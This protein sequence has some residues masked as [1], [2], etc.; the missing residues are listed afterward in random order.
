MPDLYRIATVFG[1]TGFIGR[2]IVRALAQRGIMVRVATR[3][4]ERAFFLKPC[5]TPGQIVPVACRYTDPASLSAAVRGS[6]YVVNCIGLL[7]ETRRL[8]FNQAHIEIPAAI[9]RA[10]RDHKVERFVHLSALGIDQSQSRYACTKREGEAAVREAFPAATILRPSVVFGPEDNFF[11]KFASLSRV[12][13]F[14]PL[15]GGGRTR[16]QPVFVDDV[17]EAAVCA[18]TRSALRAPDP[19]GQVFELGGPE[20]VDFPDI[21]RKLFRFTGRSRPLV[22]LPWSIARIQA[23]FLGLMPSPLLTND[24][25]ELLRSDAIVAEGALGLSD[26]GIAPSAMD[27]ILPTYLERFRS[28]GRFARKA[29]L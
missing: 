26:L 18:L 1:G 24:Q 13:P 25:V 29:A 14:L 6:D 10:C 21:Y 28:G 15:I 16:F 7:F 8:R 2:H 5:G 11:N 4:P 3:I 9:A 23:F 12:A 22:A 20:V 19:R 27:S 17:A